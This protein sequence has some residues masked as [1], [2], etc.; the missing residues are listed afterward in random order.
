MVLCSLFVSCTKE[1]GVKLE[2]PQSH[3]LSMVSFTRSSTLMTPGTATTVT[4]DYSP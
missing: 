3:E 1:E 2:I 4:E